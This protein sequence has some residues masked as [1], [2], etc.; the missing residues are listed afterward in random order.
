MIF[1]KVNPIRISPKKD[2]RKGHVKLMK[3]AVRAGM[4]RKYLAGYL[5]QGAKKIKEKD[6]T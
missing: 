3:Q 1:N 2:V 4:R 5:Y 6:N